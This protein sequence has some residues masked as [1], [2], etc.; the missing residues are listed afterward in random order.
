MNTE[1]HMTRRANQLICGPK[2]QA[3]DAESATATALALALASCTPG[4]VK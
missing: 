1:S 2:P 3:P 4:G